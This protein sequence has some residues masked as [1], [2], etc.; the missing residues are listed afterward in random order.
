[1]Q[2]VFDICRKCLR[3]ISFDVKS[4]Q[5]QSTCCKNLLHLFEHLSSL[6]SSCITAEHAISCKV[7]E[8]NS[9]HQCQTSEK[10]TKQED[11]TNPSLHNSQPKLG[12]N[13]I[14]IT[15]V[16]CK[17]LSKGKLV[18]I[19]P[20]QTSPLVTISNT[21]PTTAQNVQ[22]SLSFSSN[23]TKTFAKNIVVQA[24]SNATV[25][26]PNPVLNSPKSEYTYF[27]FPP[28]K[29]PKLRFIKPVGP[30]NFSRKGIGGLAAMPF[31]TAP[32]F[33][34]SNGTC[35]NKMPVRMVTAKPLATLCPNSI[36]AKGKLLTVLPRVS[37]INQQQLRFLH[38]S[39]PPNKETPKQ[40]ADDKS[41]SP[42]VSAKQSQSTKRKKAHSSVNA[43]K[44]VKKED[45]QS[46]STS[47][48][49][50]KTNTSEKST[51]QKSTK[52]FQDNQK[53]LSKRC[54]KSQAAGYG[55]MRIK[56]KPPSKK[57]PAEKLVDAVP[58]KT[59][60]SNYLTSTSNNNTTA[61]F[62]TTSSSARRR[63]SKPR[64]TVV[65]KTLIFCTDV[66]FS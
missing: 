51:S 47:I 25:L 10:N 23:P 44:R 53:T 14:K 39:A 54:S 50:S 31:Q 57:R 36:V 48:S 40:T 4:E 3:Q 55:K 45:D 9:N 6:A 42:L 15:V 64:Y 1:M 12:P 27:K 26:S 20:K 11:I 19:R 24:S 60:V 2:V 16:R 49:K 21:A 29:H 65:C 34:R 66:N 43:R 8:K 59:I 46:K 63:R 28:L 52:T 33:L 58:M 37:S 38:S 22:P 13:S 5:S 17:E 18:K 35:F 61:A 30:R 41:I 62:T 56:M 32:I 7:K